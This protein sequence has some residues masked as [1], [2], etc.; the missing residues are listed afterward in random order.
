MATFQLANCESFARL[1]DVSF[2]AS[3][4]LFSSSWCPTMDLFVMAVPLSNRHRLGLWKMGGTKVWD[5]EV[6]KLTEGSTEQTHSIVNVAWSPDGGLQ[7][8]VAHDPPRLSFHSVHN[9]AELRS[10]PLQISQKRLDGIW[11]MQGPDPVE[12][13]GVTKLLRREGNVPGSAHSVLQMLPLLDALSDDTSSTSAPLYNIKRPKGGAASTQ[14]KSVLPLELEKFPTLPQDPIAAS[15]SDVSATA[16]QAKSKDIIPARTERRDRSLENTV[17]VTS[18]DKG[19]L[20]LFLEGS[21]PLGEASL[22]FPCTIPSLHRPSPRSPFFTHPKRTRPNAPS[23]SPAPVML[24]FPLLESQSLKNVAKVSTTVRTLLSYIIKVLEEMRKAWFG[25]ESLEGGR[26][27]GRKWI[28]VLEEQERMFDGATTKTNPIWELTNL[29]FTGKTSG[30]MRE[31][32]GGHGKLSERGMAQ[33]ESTVQGSLT[34]LQ[35]SAERRVSPACERL[36]IVLEEARG[37]AV[38]SQQYAPYMFARAEIDECLALCHRAIE[39]SEW[40]SKTAEIEFERFHEFMRWM[41]AETSRVTDGV[42]GDLRA[43]TYDPLEVSEYL[44]HGLLSSSLDKWFVGPMPQLNPSEVVRP[45]NPRSMADLLAEVNTVVDEEGEDP[46]RPSQSSFDSPFPP[47]LSQV[48]APLEDLDRNLLAL[49]NEL[50]VKCAAVFDRAAGATGRQA[51]VEGST[52]SASRFVSP[53]SSRRSL[54]PLPMPSEQSKILFRD[55]LVIGSSDDGDDKVRSQLL[56]PP[57]PHVFR[58]VEAD[59]FLR[60]G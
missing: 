25:T 28:K 26:D 48:H 40:L 24:R 53:K 30:A 12:P 18:D 46:W 42:V 27:V 39:L 35:E 57:P 52:K 6:A 15:I 31:F 11:W 38:W 7:I 55:R 3:S 32:L 2:P 8:A 20:Y 10:I 54:T 34:I 51:I 13:D 1:A 36:I 49:A 4:K 29:L 9:G 60:F 19:M 33:W 23:T 43:P 45:S 56:A 5:I 21:Y 58:I 59:W 22:G 44:D 16:A 50:A 47:G 41:K 37:W 17:V 14:R